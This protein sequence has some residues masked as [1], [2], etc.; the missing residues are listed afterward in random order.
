MKTVGVLIAVVF[1]LT[2]GLA[3]SMAWAE[4]VRFDNGVTFS[5]LG[6]APDCESVIGVGAG[7]L[8]NEEPGEVME[9]GI[10]FFEPIMPGTVAIGRCAGALAPSPAVYNGVTVFE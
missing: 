6:S 4:E 9:N 7:G 3:A 5:D 2:L 1:A 10:T 8:I